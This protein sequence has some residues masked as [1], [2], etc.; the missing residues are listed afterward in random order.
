M[1]KAVCVLSK[2]SMFSMC[3]FPEINAMRWPASKLVILCHACL[4][5]FF[6]P[7]LVSQPHTLATRQSVTSTTSPALIEYSDSLPQCLGQ[8]SLYIHPCLLMYI[9]HVVHMILCTRCPEGIYMDGISI[10]YNPE[11]IYKSGFTC[12]NTF[13]WFMTQVIIL[14]GI[15]TGRGKFE[16]PKI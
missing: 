9:L 12:Q 6:S 1:P 16:M 5:I 4:D 7:K 14:K 2:Q 10:N 8:H 3:V 11:Q 15:L 13:L